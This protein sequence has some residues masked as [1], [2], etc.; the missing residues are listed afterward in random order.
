M[1]P[2]SAAASVGPSPAAP[3][4]APITQSAGRWRRLDQR[5]LAGARLD[6]GAGERILELAIGGRI[7]D[8]RE[9]GT[10]VARQRR[11][12]RGTAIGAH[13]LDP[14]ALAAGA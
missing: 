3:V 1:A 14:V 9:A 4:I 8:R 2:R 12:R 6:A 7:A 10:E 13:R 11:E 5:A